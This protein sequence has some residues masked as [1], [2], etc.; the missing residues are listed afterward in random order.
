MPRKARMY[1]PRVPAYVA[2]PSNN[3]NACFSVM[4]IINT[5]KPCYCTIRADLHAYCLMINHVHLLLTPL[6]ED[7][8][9]LALQH[10][11]R[12]YV[13]H[14]N[15]TY[16]RTGTLWEGRHKSSLIDTE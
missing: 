15:Q 12:Q 8:I 11:G 7:S 16:K 14:I 2:Q 1:L 3:R 9:S 4:M 13:Q 5:I 6:A 10:A